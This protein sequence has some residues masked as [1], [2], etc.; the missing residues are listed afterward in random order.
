MK[1]KFLLTSAIALLIAIGWIRSGC[2]EIS[3]LERESRAEGQAFYRK[4]PHEP[5]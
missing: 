5:S 1:P 4:A 3:K 2:A